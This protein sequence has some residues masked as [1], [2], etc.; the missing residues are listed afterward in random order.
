MQNREI[1]YRQAILLVLYRGLNS[2]LST[3]RHTLSLLLRLFSCTL[4]SSSLAIAP[5]FMNLLY[6]T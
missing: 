2:A 6:H 3:V 4:A 5:F 1:G